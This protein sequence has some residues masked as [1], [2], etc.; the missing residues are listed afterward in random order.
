MM[1][2]REFIA[3]LGGAA[4]AWPLVARA[5]QAVMPVIGFLNGQS[6]ETFAHLLTAFHQGLKEPGYVEGHNATIEYRWAGSDVDKLPALAQDLVRRQ[7]AVI[8]AAGGAHLAAK[9]ATSSIPI[10]FTTP[11][12]P[13]E[14]GLVASFNRPGG[15][16]TGISVFTV[17]LE[18]K[19]FELLHELVPRE[20]TI[21]VLLDPTFSLVNLQLSEVQR[22]A[23]TTE[24]QLRVLKVSTDPDIDEAFSTLVQVHAGGVVV[25]GNPFLNSK[26][27]KIIALA[28]RNAIPAIYEPRESTTAGGLMNYG[29]SITDVYRQLGVYTGRV[30]KGEKPADLPVLQPTKFDL[31]IN[32]KTAR[33]LGLE[34]PPTLFARADEVIE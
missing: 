11:G 32:L 5:Q 27:N 8:A 18:A 6:P 23:R 3:G 9:A 24:R 16:A 28:A 1:N 34:V 29:P 13:V 12:E 10:V 2:R 17:T 19:R 20:A 4:A 7:V 15:N 26:R 31:L 21:G 25:S 30:L 33:T 22:A 14:E